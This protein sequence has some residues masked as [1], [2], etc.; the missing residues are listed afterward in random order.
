MGAPVARPA[1]KSD[2][3][4][5]PAMFWRVLFEIELLTPSPSA[6]WNTD[7]TCPPSAQLRDEQDSAAAEAVLAMWGQMMCLL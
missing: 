7:S 5:A 3:T 4:Q 1:D 6:R 2:S